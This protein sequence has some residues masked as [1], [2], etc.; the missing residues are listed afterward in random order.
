MLIAKKIRKLKL[1]KN[2]EEN[3]KEHM[4]I[5]FIWPVYLAIFIHYRVYL[6]VPPPTPPLNYFP[7]RP[8]QPFA[9]EILV[10]FL[11]FFA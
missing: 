11:V 6:I 2:V 3:N 1:H 8:S 10:L 9:I 4:E 5:T 7:L